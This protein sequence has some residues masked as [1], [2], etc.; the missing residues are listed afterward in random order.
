MRSVRLFVLAGAVAL[1]A[2]GDDAEIPL[3]RTTASDGGGASAGTGGDG[4]G[5][6]GTNGDCQSSAECGGERPYCS[7]TLHRCVQCV[8]SATCAPLACDPGGYCAPACASDSSCT[9][10]STPRC[11][12]AYGACVQC[13]D[14]SDCQNFDAKICVGGHCRECQTDADCAGKPT[15]PYC[16]LV[17]HE[18]RQ[19]L[20]D[21]NCQTG[22]HCDLED[23][24]C[25]W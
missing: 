21:K 23:H 19:C 16:E 9:D 18:C 7:T 15:T 1:S 3:L 24:E 4:G 12:T 22:Q 17:Q 10:A 13:L 2:C 6:G 25:R 20:S 5:S 8:A 11:D 14:A